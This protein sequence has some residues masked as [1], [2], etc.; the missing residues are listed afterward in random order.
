MLERLCMELRRAR[1]PFVRWT[2]WKGE[3]TVCHYL[4]QCAYICHWKDRWKDPPSAVLT[5]GA[6]ERLMS[7][8]FELLNMS[9]VIE[10]T[11]SLLGVGVFVSPFHICFAVSSCLIGGILLDAFAA[12]VIESNNIST[13]PPCTDILCVWKGRT[14]MRFI[15]CW[16]LLSICT[17]ETHIR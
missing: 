6:N 8:K 7:V 5:L 9:S 3:V 16:L 11:R 10:C 12:C 1:G 2:R 14:A 17:N 15:S 4:P 13:G